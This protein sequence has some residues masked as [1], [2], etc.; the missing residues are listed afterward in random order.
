LLDESWRNKRW[1]VETDIASCFEAI[2]HDR[3][4]TAIEDR[5]CDQQVLKLLRALLRAGVLEDGNV[6]RPVTGTPQGGVISPLLANVY[7]TGLTGH[8][9]LTATGCWCATPTTC[10]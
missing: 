5:V 9:T 3:L 1:V 8:G 7:C 2:P 4:M 6:R 10:W